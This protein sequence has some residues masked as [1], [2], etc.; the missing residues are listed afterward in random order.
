MKYI[1]GVLS[2]FVLAA[3]QVNTNSNAG[4]LMQV[5]PATGLSCPIVGDTALARWITDGKTLQRLLEGIHRT[6]IGKEIELPAFDFQQRSLLLVSMGK[7]PNPAYRLELLDE[8]LEREGTDRVLH[9][10]WRQP[11]PGRM[12]A[13][14][15]TYPCLWLEMPKLTDSGIRIVDEQ[16]RQR[17]YLPAKN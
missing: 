2:L 14:V 7:K 4:E 6:V 11:E 1:L 16:N 3:C 12:Y 9:L 13:A 8:K 10:R 15:I 17:L 5:K